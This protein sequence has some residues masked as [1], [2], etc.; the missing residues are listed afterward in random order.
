M[1]PTRMLVPNYTPLEHLPVPRP[2]HRL[3]RL[4]L[5]CAGKNVLDLG[6]MDETAYRSKRGRGDW[7]HEELAKVAKQVVGIDNSP[8]VPESGLETAPNASIHRGDIMR[9]S[10][11]WESLGKLNRFEPD[12]VVAGELIEHLPNP[13]LFLQS[14]SKNPRLRGKLLV[15]TTPNATA[16]HN[17]IIGLGSRES[18]HHDHLSILSYKTLCTLFHRAGYLSWEITPYYAQFPEMKQRQKG[19]GRWLIAG[20]ERTINSLEW[21]FPLMSFGFVVSA[22]I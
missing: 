1:Q 12:V 16:L 13:L 11:S 10:D 5:L 2:C 7:L 3:Q 4:K 18:T 8:L 9:L 21:L 6:A 20:G 17:C 19:V 22:T 14:I 15:I